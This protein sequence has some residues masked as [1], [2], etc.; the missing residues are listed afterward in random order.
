MKELN[1]FRKFLNEGTEVVDQ[2]VFSVKY[3]DEMEGLEV[4]L[5]VAANSNEDW[6]KQ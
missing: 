4:T 5:Y 1:N 2:P 6:P 3:Q